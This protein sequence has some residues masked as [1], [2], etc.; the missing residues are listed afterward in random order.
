MWIRI[1][2]FIDLFIFSFGLKKVIVCQGYDVELFYFILVGIGELLFFNDDFK[3]INFIF[4][5]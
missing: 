2:C 4:F 5:N 1:K 3:I